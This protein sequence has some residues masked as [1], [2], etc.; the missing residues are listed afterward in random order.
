ME[1]VDE[2]LIAN[3]KQQQLKQFTGILNNITLTVGEGALAL[4]RVTKAA[5]RWAFTRRRV[6]DCDKRYTWHEHGDGKAKGSYL[7]HKL[8]V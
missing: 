3:Q 1:H 4:G 5:M 2:I 7:D 8:K 6:T